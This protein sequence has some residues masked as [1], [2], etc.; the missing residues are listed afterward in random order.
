M[1]ISQVVEHIEDEAWLEQCVEF[2]MQHAKHAHPRVRYAV[3]WA[4]AQIS[5][6]QADSVS[7]KQEELLKIILEGIDDENI[8]VA[9]TAVSAFTAMGDDI[10]YC[11]VEDDF[12]K[13]LLQGLIK[14]LQ[15]K[16]SRVMQEN[17]LSAVASI[18][19]EA[20][21]DQFSNFYGDVMPLIKQVIVNANKEDEKR[22]RGKAFECVSVIGQAV[23]KDMFLA[24]AHETM[25][26]MIKIIQGGFAADDEQKESIDTAA[27][28][29]AVVLGKD[30]KPYIFSLLPDIFKTLEQRPK[31]ITES[32]LPNVDDDDAPEMSFEIVG[33]KY[34][35]LKTS[36]LTDMTNAIDLLNKFIKASEETFCEFLPGTCEKLLPL[37]DMSLSDEDLLESTYT[38]LELLTESARF[39][40]EKGCLDA[41]V[42]RNL[43]TEFLKKIVIAKLAAESDLTDHA[44]LSS[45][46]AASAGAAGVVKSA[47]PGALTPDVLK[48]VVGVVVALLARAASACQKDDEVPAKRR[49]GLEGNTGDDD[50]D[51]DEEEEEEPT[52]QALR[53][54]L[55]DVLGALM[56][57]YPEAF[58]EVALRG[59][60]ELVRALLQ[61]ESSDCD[62]ALAFYIVDEAVE[63]LGEK[64]V[65]YWNWFMNQALQGVQDKSAV[66]RQYATSTL[67]NSASQAMFAQMAPAAAAAVYAVLQKHGERHKRRRAVKADSKQTALSID[68]AIR[69][70][71]QI[72][73]E[74]EKELG[75]HAEVAWNMWL[76]SLPMK[77]DVEAGKKA[78]VQLMAL[79]GRGHPAMASAER[80]R[81]VVQ[82]LVDVYK[83]KFS[84]SELDAAIVAAVASIGSEEQRKQ[85]CAGFPEK[86]QKKVE[87]I[88]KNAAK[89]AGS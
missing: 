74:Q 2:V 18:A 30:F 31:E 33:G 65:P 57:A 25:A 40:A 35:G 80:H 45:L 34:Y 22:L 23:G 5:Y 54:R 43:V 62:R 9:T 8:R 60:M 75:T 58:T 36:I 13:E 27:G 79:V 67:G 55:A 12:V 52:A 16:E 39:A 66:V 17:C 69:T 61:N 26:A 83:T 37:L 53:F 56:R 32:E 85:L 73:A 15:K 88:A 28:R 38:A 76:S 86:T 6:D 10:D 7:S 24:D 82:I 4:I 47:G 29:I 77:Y 70:L 3:F 46:L 50:D 49:R 19:E 87:Q 59:Y 81:R 64:T 11:D 48:D 84:T 20:V 21:E 41:G 44:V 14:R 68:A 89:N 1:A 63:C 78:H 72:A 71:G 42:L 51:E